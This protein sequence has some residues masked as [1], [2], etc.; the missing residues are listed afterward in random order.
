VRL[1]SSGAARPRKD[2]RSAAAR[3][4]KQKCAFESSDLVVRTT[5][6]TVSISLD[7]QLCLSSLISISLYS[8]LLLIT[9]YLN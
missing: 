8:L 7:G 2:S 9:A 3:V 1:V 6:I 4:A 5:R